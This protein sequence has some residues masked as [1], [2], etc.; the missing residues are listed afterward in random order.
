M[1]NVAAEAA[2]NGS[3]VLKLCVGLANDG[4]DPSGM[5]HLE[6]GG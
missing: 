5:F 1:S 2:A 4:A 3:N 6:P